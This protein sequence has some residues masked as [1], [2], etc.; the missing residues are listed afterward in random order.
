MSS[1]PQAVIF[2]MNGVIVDD[3]RIHQKSW[4][5]FC[6]DHGFRLTEDEFKQKVFGRIEKE[7]FEY[8][9]KRH[10]T[11]EEVAQYSDERVDTAIRLVKPVLEVVAGVLGVLRF[12]KEH[13]IQIALATSSRRRY[14][15]LI[16]DSLRLDD[17]F[18]AIVTAEDIS[19]GKPDPEIYLLAAKQLS[20]EP[21]ECV[22][23]EDSVSGI[24]SAQKAG[25]KVIGIATTH[26][27]EE[28]Q[29]ADKVVLDFTSQSFEQLFSF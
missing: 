14:Q 11:E 8:L 21:K 16:F 2:D 22:A 17:F 27:P 1:L 13:H 4:R 3:E 23:I 19:K 20:V 28:I 29:Q 5:K 18:D 15:R 9:F 24:R 6:H 25:M 7:T 12:L 26:T 10:L